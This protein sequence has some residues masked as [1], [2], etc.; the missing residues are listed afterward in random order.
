MLRVCLFCIKYFT[1]KKWFTF[2]FNV[3]LE[4]YFTVKYFTCKIIFNNGGD[5][6]GEMTM[7]V[8]EV[9]VR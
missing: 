9:V 1:N 7:M 5:G 2:K 6:G 8:K 4:K 3:W